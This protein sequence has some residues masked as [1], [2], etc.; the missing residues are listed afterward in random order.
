MRFL[1]AQEIREMSGK[2][3]KTSLKLAKKT[4][5]KSKKEILEKVISATKNR[6]TEQCFD[7]FYP[8]GE[9][10]IDKIYEEEYK[11][12]ATEFFSSLGYKV[13][14]GSVPSIASTNVWSRL[15][16]NWERNEE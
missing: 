2:A 1:T 8:I 16:L 9:I 7:L 12:I 11:R 14:F 6:R 3:D 10:I 13:F 4:F 5:E 15:W